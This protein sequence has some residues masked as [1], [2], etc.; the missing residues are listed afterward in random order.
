MH[1]MFTMLMVPSLRG[2]GIQPILARCWPMIGTAMIGVWLCVVEIFGR[3]G[4]PSLF[5]KLPNAN[6]SGLKPMLLGSRECI[7][8]FARVIEMKRHV[9]VAHAVPS[10]DSIKTDL[11]PSVCLIETCHMHCS[12]KGWLDRHIEQC[13]KIRVQTPSVQLGKES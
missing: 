6:L 10:I 11:R 1:L 8:M 7:R 12:T 13:H 3:S 9:R 5:L 4:S 2:S